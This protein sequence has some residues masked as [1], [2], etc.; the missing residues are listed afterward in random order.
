VTTQVTIVGGGSYQWAP[1]LIADLIG[2]PSLAGMRL[3]LYDIDPN[4]LPKMEVLAHKVNGALEAHTTVAI[5]TDLGR[6]LDGANF[7]IVCIST[8]GF[9]SMAVD[10]DVPA[11]HGITQTVGDSVGPG[12]INRALRNIPCWSASAKPWRSTAP[13]PGSSTSPTR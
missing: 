1:E 9:R 3:V 7:V 13:R 11:A 10:L 12:G 6:A 8:D 4:P 5:T 2:T